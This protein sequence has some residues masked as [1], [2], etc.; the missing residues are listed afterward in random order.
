MRR[1][2]ILGALRDAD[3]QQPHHVPGLRSPRHRRSQEG[4]AAQERARGRSTRSK[5][6]ADVFFSARR[7]P[8]IVSTPLSAVGSSMSCF[9]QTRH[10]S[11]H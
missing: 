3:F 10:V 7:S 9:D 2:C 11:D 4:E 8:R 6:S 5:P 1:G